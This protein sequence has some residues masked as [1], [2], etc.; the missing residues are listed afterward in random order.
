MLMFAQIEGASGYLARSGAV[1]MRSML[2]RKINGY[3]KANE[4]LIVYVS[5]LCLSGVSK[6]NSR[7]GDNRGGIGR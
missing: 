6:G 7:G 1:A 5:R 4:R 2:S 3:Q